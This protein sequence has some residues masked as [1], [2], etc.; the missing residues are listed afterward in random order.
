M[1]R[2]HTQRGYGKGR[3]HAFIGREVCIAAGQTNYPGR[4]GSQEAQIYLAN[5]MTV[6]ASCLEGKIADPRKYRER[7]LQ[8]ET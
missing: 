7:R 6:A 1:C 5:P 2:A 4:M 8:G 3:E